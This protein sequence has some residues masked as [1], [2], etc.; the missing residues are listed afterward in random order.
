MFSSVQES[1]IRYGVL[2][3]LGGHQAVENK[4]VETINVTGKHVAMYACGPPHQNHE[5]RDALSPN[6]ST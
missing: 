4:S 5:K 2:R 1:E 6:P 3:A